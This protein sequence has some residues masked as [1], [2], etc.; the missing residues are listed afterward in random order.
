MTE[1]DTS[2]PALWAERTGT[3][4]YIGRSSRGAE[5]PIGEGPG[6]FT[7]GELLQIALAG[8]VGLSADHRLAHA[9]GPDFAAVVGVSRAKDETANRY[10]SFAVEVVADLDGL[11]EDVRARTVERAEIAIER[12]CT[13]GRTLEAGAGHTL[14]FTSERPS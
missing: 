5:V 14:R 3:R 8:C 9:L 6:A 4:T 1:D 7:P 10:T 11:A 2:P 13:V 12:Q